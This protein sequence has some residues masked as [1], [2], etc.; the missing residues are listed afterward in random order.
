MT[1]PRRE[2]DRVGLAKLDD[3]IAM[4]ERMIQQRNLDMSN[5][6]DRCTRVKVSDATTPKGGLTMVYID[7]FWVV[8]PEDEI[9]LYRT[10]PQCNSDRVLAE[11]LL[12]KLY[13]GC[14]V[15]QIPAVFIK[16]DPSEWRDS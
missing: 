10:S 1:E 5:A 8:T 9:L 3:A 14:E 7:R 16:S 15:R 2:G 4:C 13:P 11:R 6:I 12:V